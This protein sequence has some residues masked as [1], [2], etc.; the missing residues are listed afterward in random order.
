MV[1][2]PEHLERWESRGE[3]VGCPGGVGGWVGAVVSYGDDEELGE[4]RGDGRGGGGRKGEGFVTHYCG[5]VP[6][7]GGTAD[8]GFGEVEVEEGGPRAL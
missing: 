4:E 3:F 1:S 7:S 2:E 5:E 8:G 6:T